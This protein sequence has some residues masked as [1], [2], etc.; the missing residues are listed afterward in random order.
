M[1][2][3]DIAARYPDQYGPGRSNPQAQNELE[4]VTVLSYVAGATSRA[5]LGISV[6]VLPFR[7]PV[8]NAKM[9]TTLDVLSGGMAIFGVGVGLMP[10]EFQSI[11]AS[12]SDWGALTNE[13]IEMFK[14][15]C[16]QDIADYQGNHFQISGMTFSPSRHK[17][18]IHRYGWVVTQT[19][20]FVA[21]PAWETA[22]TE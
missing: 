5:R 3:A 7:N 18:L 22:G 1:F 9:I 10:E 17:S 16:T 2:P 4:A 12:Y 11:G 14:A 20:P 6:L 21:P 8:L 15:L 13:H 19:L